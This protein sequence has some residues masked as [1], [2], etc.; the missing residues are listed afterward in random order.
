MDLAMN[1]LI[2]AAD[3]ELD[4]PLFYAA[5][6]RCGAVLAVAVAGAL[7]AIPAPCP[8]GHAAYSIRYKDTPGVPGVTIARGKVEIKTRRKRKG[9][10]P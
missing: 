1:D 2:P 8:C 9:A 4:M 5:C 7:P 3:A 10:R 6:D